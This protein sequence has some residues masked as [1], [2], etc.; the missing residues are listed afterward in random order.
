MCLELAEV[1]TTPRQDLEARD[2]RDTS[3]L[4]Q[5]LHPALHLIGVHLLVDV[6]GQAGGADGEVVEPGAACAQVLQ[7]GDAYP[8]LQT[9]KLPV[10]DYPVTAGDEGFHVPHKWGQVNGHDGVV[11]EEG[12]GGDHSGSPPSVGQ[13]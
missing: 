7:K 12:G 1:Y 9:G 2:R 4:P 5:A 10:D 8:A 3:T 13:R 11:V 6:E